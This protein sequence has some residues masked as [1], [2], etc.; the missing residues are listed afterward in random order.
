MDAINTLLVQRSANY[1]DRIQSPI[2][3]LSRHFWSVAFMNC[4]QKWR[5]HRRTFHQFFNRK[6]V[7]QF[8]P[9]IEE[10][11]PIL[12]KALLSRPDDFRE[13]THHFFGTIIMRAAYGADD[14]EYNK[15]LTMEAD[16]MTPGKFL[17][18]FLP[19]MQHIPSWFPGAGWR[20]ALEDFAIWND[21]FI[22][23]PFKDTKARMR[24]GSQ[25]S[26]FRS[27]AVELIEELPKENTIDLQ[28]K[29]EV[30]K[31]TCAA[32][33][34]GKL[35]NL[36][37]STALSVMLALTMHP[38]IQRKAQEQI[39]SVVG[40]ERLPTFSDFEKL[41]YLQAV[42]K[43][44]GRWH[45]VVPLALPHV[46]TEEDIYE[47]MRIPAG[48][49]VM[50]NGWAVMHDPKNFDDP[51][52]FKPERYLKSNGQIDSAVLDH[53]ST[54]F[55]YGRRVCPGRYLSDDTLTSMTAAFL[56]CFNIKPAEGQKEPLRLRTSSNAVSY[57]L[58]F[59]CKIEPRSR[60]YVSLIN[61]L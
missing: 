34:L 22:S 5:D 59:E 52:E 4:G 26:L 39:D 33:Y 31:N 41:P 2:I 37:V 12:L 29:E 19:S 35:C 44:A 32:A 30:A 15:K 51:F 23:V 60:H 16:V 11:I 1:S 3:K 40:Q 48:T 55:G 28:Y 50:P 46:S 43:E 6:E 27:M 24:N 57:P 25:K 53:H 45:A 8:R 21:R 13:A 38:D 58:P 20:R 56:T 49:M 9:I 18:G 61:N 17:V 47:G 36:T 10:E 54:S 42:I 7:H 14:P